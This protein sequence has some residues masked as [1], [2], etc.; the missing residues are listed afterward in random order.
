MKKSIFVVLAGVAFFCIFYGIR[1]V[2]NP[3]DTQA[4]ILE[5]YENKVDTSGYIVRNEQVYS[6]PAAGTVYHYLQEGTR[7]KKNSVLSTVYTGGVSEETLRELNNINSKIAELKNSGG[8]TVSGSAGGNDIENI[9]KNIISAGISGDTS[10]ME[11]YKMQL[12]S[13]ITGDVQNGSSDSIDALAERKQALEAGMMNYKN[14][15]YSQMSGVF[16]K[17]VDGLETVLTPQSIMSYKAADYNGIAEE[18]KSTDTVTDTDQPVCKVVNNHTWYV[19]LTVDRQTADKLKINQKAK[20]RFEYLPGI[21]ADAEICYISTEDSGTDKNVVVLKSEQY[22]EGVFS[23]RFSGIE[24]ILESYEGYRVP[25]SAIRIVD[26]ERGVL[27]KNGGTQVFKPCNIIYSDTKGQT[28]IIRP[29][30]GA[31]NML[32]EYDNIVVGEK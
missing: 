31:A 3:V 14:D 19:M 16:S 1:Y 28:A 4:A 7:V 15:I 6:A 2:E 11:G 10:G 32:R 23:I 8:Y 25:V 26:N 27:V 17:N 5:V 12:S 21:E 20:L 18:M 22:K 9:R 30:S 29:V 13:V 24:L